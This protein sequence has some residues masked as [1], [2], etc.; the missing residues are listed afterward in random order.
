MDQVQCYKN[1]LNIYLFLYQLGILF[2]LHLYSGLAPSKITAALVIKSLPSLN[3]EAINFSS[4]ITNSFSILFNSYSSFSIG[5]KE[6]TIFLAV[7]R[8][9]T[10]LLLILLPILLAIILPALE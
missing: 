1:Y 5:L 6:M 4:N 7:A 10:T 9:M 3:C 8:L 2:Y